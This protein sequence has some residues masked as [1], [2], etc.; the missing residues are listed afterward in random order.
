MVYNIADIYRKEHPTDRVHA[1]YLYL[2]ANQDID[3][4]DTLINLHDP[5]ICSYLKSFSQSEWELFEQRMSSWN[6]AAL[7]NIADA[8][9]SATNEHI[10][11]KYLYA[12]IFLQTENLEGLEYLVQNIHLVSCI[13][14]G[15]CGIDFYQEIKQKIIKL[16]KHFGSDY[17]YW[18]LVLDL[19]IESEIDHFNSLKS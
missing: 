16:S 13:P 2:E 12:K 18:L 10:S 11:V 14:I 8:L 6:E 3:E 4:G 19:K 9:L 7:F 5:E 1:L 17:S 15:E